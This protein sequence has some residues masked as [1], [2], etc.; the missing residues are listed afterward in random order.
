M[1]K[2][3]FPPT[4]LL[5][6]HVLALVGCSPLL[7]HVL[8]AW[9]GEGDGGA[10]K[11][12]VYYVVFVWSYY[13]FIAFIYGFTMYM[14]GFIAANDGEHTKPRAFVFITSVVAMVIS[15]AQFL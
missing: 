9:L 6:K 11:L 14:A 5:W 4:S 8:N 10:A 12:V 1:S 7:L 15:A 13:F 2:L 3:S